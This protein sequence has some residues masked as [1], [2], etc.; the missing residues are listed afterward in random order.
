MSLPPYLKKQ[1]FIICVC[2]SYIIY[3]IFTFIILTQPQHYHALWIPP[4]SAKLISAD[5]DQ[6]SNDF[7]ASLLQCRW[8]I[9][10]ILFYTEFM[11]IVYQPR[12]STEY[13]FISRPCR[14]PEHSE[15]AGVPQGPCER[16]AV[17]AAGS[18]DQALGLSGG[19]TLKT[20]E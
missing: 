19:A 7:S 1:I 10:F 12:L 15:R 11:T 4:F 8:L 5:L 2:K 6:V 20:E 18:Q 13:P 16:A 14:T 3:D 9:G 17:H